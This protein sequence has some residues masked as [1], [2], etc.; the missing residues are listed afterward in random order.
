MTRRGLRERRDDETVRFQASE[1]DINAA[2]M[3]SPSLTSTAIYNTYSSSWSKS[4]TRATKL[5]LTRLLRTQMSSSSASL[6]TDPKAWKSAL[7]SLPSTPTKIPAF[8]FGHGSPIL[9]W[10][11]GVPAPFGGNGSPMYQSAGPKGPLVQFLKDFGRTLVEKYK[12]KG[13][14]VFSAHWETGGE[15]LGMSS[16][17]YDLPHLNFKFN[18]LEQ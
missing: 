8:F 5:H 7:D 13:I 18:S 2:A 11:D 15:R 4:L 16:V 17:R 9:Q 14:L 12:P 3:T 1:L 6:P 10:P